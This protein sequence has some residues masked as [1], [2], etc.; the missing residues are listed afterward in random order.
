MYGICN[1][2]IVP[3]RLEPDDRSEMVTQLLLGDMF[4]ILE[5]QEAWMQIQNSFDEYIGW[6]S[7]KQYTPISEQFYLE[8]KNKN[9]SMVGDMASV[10]THQ[11]TH[12]IQ[13]VVLGSMLPGYKEEAFLLGNQKYKYEGTVQESVSSKNLRHALIETAYLYLYSPYLWGGKTPFGIDCSGFTQMVYKLCGLT[14][15]RDAS[16]QAQ[17][18]TSLSFIEEALP[19]DLAFFDN[20]EGKII[21]TGIVLKNQ[22]I[23]HASGCVRID[24][25]DHQ[26][27]YNQEQKKYTHNLRVIKN[28]L[29]D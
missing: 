28:I 18:G 12:E 19:G 21:H 8:F 22:C 13:T 15:W 25:L 23:I 10:I 4:L 6:I 17:L 9:T 2:S 14:I 11:D 5:K 7:T 20:S 26:G 29:S 27:I 3:V 24:S 1:L 16:Q